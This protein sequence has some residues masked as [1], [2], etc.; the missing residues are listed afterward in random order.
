MYY[1]HISIVNDDSNDVNKFVASLTD[2]ARVNIYDRN[3]FIIQ[4]TGR[5]GFLKT[6]MP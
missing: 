6:I 2:N 1:K 4:A 3:M 5:S